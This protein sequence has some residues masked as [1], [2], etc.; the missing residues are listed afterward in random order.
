MAELIGIVLG[1]ITFATI[2]NTITTLK[3]YY[4]NFHDAPDDLRK[5]VQEIELFGFILADIREDLS[6]NTAKELDIVC[7]DIFREVRSPNRLRRSLKSVRIVLQKGKIEKYKTHL[8]Y[9]IQLP[10]LSQ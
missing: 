1:A 10:I 2:R 6:Q 4:D 9:A 3:E 8:R 5:L 7:T